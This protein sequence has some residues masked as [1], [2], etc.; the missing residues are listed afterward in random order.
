M[1]TDLLLERQER[2]NALRWERNFFHDVTLCYFVLFCVIYRYLVLFSV[3]LSLFQPEVD[4]EPSNPTPAPG[5]VKLERGGGGYGHSANPASAG[6]DLAATALSHRHHRSGDIK[7]QV[8]HPA[9][10][11]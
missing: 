2:K 10:R 3:P 1:D 5:D 8:L 6:L 7:E 9:I 11:L 4:F